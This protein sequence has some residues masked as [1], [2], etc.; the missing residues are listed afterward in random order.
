MNILFLVPH[1]DDEVLGF[2]GTICK[3]VNQGHNIKVVI[4]QAP[5]HQRATKQLSDAVFAKDI[6]GYSELEFLSIPHHDLCNDLFGLIS[7]VEHTI[8]KFKPD[9]LYT[10]HNSD[11][12]QDH[13]NVFRAVSIATRPNTCKYAQKIY[14][15]EVISSCDQSFSIERSSFIPNTYETLNHEHIEKKIA[16]LKSYTTECQQLPHSRCPE[17]ILAKATSRGA[18]CKSMYAEAFMLLRDI[19]SV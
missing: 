14:V 9:I 8:D 10:T 2:G 19:K 1:A 17:S 7:K 16:A 13:K 3:L 11:N 5:N 12:H 15:G 18:E 6:L 4:A